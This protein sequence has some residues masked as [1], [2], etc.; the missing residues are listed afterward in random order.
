[1]IRFGV[2]VIILKTVAGWS[3]ISTER[4]GGAHRRLAIVANRD[5]QGVSARHI[6]LLPNRGWNDDP[7]LC[8]ELN[9]EYHLLIPS[10]PTNRVT[11]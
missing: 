3:L 11:T 2:F 9:A 8:L 5:L 6:N 10:S 4:A 1:M 7:S